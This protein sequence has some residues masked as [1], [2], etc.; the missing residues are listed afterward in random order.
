MRTGTCRGFRP[1][2]AD[3]IAYHPHGVR[4]APDVRTPQRDDAGLADLPRLEALL[5]AIQRRGGLRNSRHAARKFDLYLTEYGYQTNPPDRVV[6]VSPARQAAWLQ[7]G[8]YMAWRDPRV[9]NLTQY[10]WRD[11]RVG[12]NGAGWQSGLL[13]VDDRPKPALRGFPQPFWAD[14]G[15]GRGVARL[16]GQVRPGGAHAV[17]VQR[18][19]AGSSRWTTVRT[20]R[21]DG[22]GFFVLRVRVTGRVGY[23]FTWQPDGGR[24][25]RTSDVRRVA[26][27]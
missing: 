27:R 16:W 6:G 8:A 7:Q 25:L 9:R 4:R 24:A 12:F 21:T 3:G 17:A 5:D 23:R 22:R 20:L 15:V 11:E 10:V 2:A 26:P 14:P 1:A 13:F 19:A 18:R